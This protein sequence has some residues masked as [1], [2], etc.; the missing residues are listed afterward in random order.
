MSADASA[1]S[2][3][4]HFKLINKARRAFEAW[5][6]DQDKS[7]KFPPIYY[8]LRSFNQQNSRVRN[9][10]LGGDTGDVATPPNASAEAASSTISVGP[11]SK[12]VSP[13]NLFSLF[14]IAIDSILSSVARTRPLSLQKSSKTLVAKRRLRLSTSTQQIAPFLLFPLPLRPV[15][16][17]ISVSKS[18]DALPQMTVDTEVPV[19]VDPDVVLAPAAPISSEASV[20]TRRRSRSCSAM[21][22]ASYP[23]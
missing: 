5:Q 17:L 16:S 23:R 19:A 2:K 11:P 8:Q 6:N 13:A 20:F 3:P 10:G 4:D 22:G 12:K 1:L 7:Y 18:P 15:S 21:V 14:V 9:K